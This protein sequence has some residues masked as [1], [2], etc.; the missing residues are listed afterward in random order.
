[1]TLMEVT[2]PVGRPF[3]YADLEAMPDDGHQYEIFDGLLVVSPSPIPVHQRAVVRLAGLLDAACPSGL[4]TFVARLDVK[5]TDTMVLEPDV[6]VARVSDIGEKNVPAAPVLVVEVLSPSTR[7]YDMLLKRA[8]YEEHGVG[9]Y[10][11]VDPKEPS[12][13]VLELAGG[14]YTE[15]AHV[16]GDEVFEATRPFPVRVCPAELV[17]PR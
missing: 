2:V 13:T 10:W 15:V 6:L 8:A 7:R 11:L 16:M 17:T 4:E 14:V 9:S 12:L 3:T 1:M 5:L